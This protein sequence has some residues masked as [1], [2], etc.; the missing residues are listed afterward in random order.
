MHPLTCSRRAFYTF[1]GFVVCHLCKLRNLSFWSQRYCHLCR[2]RF[3]A[4]RRSLNMQ[5][6]AFVDAAEAAGAEAQSSDFALRWRGGLWDAYRY[7][8]P[9]ETATN[10]SG[11]AGSGSWPMTSRPGATASRLPPRVLS[12]AEL[13]YDAEFDMVIA[14]AELR[15]VRLANRLVPASFPSGRVIPQMP[16]P[17]PLSSTHV[18]VAVRP[19]PG[20]QTD[21]V[22]SALVLKWVAEECRKRAYREAFRCLEELERDLHRAVPVLSDEQKRWYRSQVVVRRVRDDHR[23][24]GIRQARAT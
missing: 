1:D 6:N 21:L 22:P 7:V 19:R 13:L 17:T 3:K 20:S 14:L 23:P 16:M 4:Y 5:Y 15:E 12:T 11:S 9:L 24:W 10:P 2:V 8:P 18:P